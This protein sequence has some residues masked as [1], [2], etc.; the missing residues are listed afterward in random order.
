MEKERVDRTKRNICFSG[1]DSPCESL[2]ISREELGGCEGGRQTQLWLGWQGPG[3]RRSPAHWGDAVLLGGLRLKSVGDR[4]GWPSP[5]TGA[6][7]PC[8]LPRS[9]PGIFC[10]CSVVSRPPVPLGVWRWPGLR[11]R[12]AY[13]NT[14]R[15]MLPAPGTRHSAAPGSSGDKAH[16]DPEDMLA[17]GPFTEGLTA[18][19]EG[20][21]GAFKCS[22]LLSPVPFLVP[23]GAFGYFRM[24]S[25]C[26]ASH[27]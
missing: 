8:R 10:S 20:H 4:S 3:S 23:P 12:T 18:G 16:G 6:G 9:H 14:T 2:V 21:A 26:H 22:H 11:G 19:R 5:G 24:P 27:R 1:Q 7:G 13:P 15:P 17:P 25:H